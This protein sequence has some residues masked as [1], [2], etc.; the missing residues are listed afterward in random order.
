MHKSR[1]LSKTWNLE[2]NF[3]L[4]IHYEMPEARPRPGEGPELQLQLQT[5]LTSSA[6]GGMVREGER[7]WLVASTMMK[8]KERRKIS[9]VHLSFLF[10]L[11]TVRNHRSEASSSPAPSTNWI[12]RRF[13]PNFFFLSFFG[14]LFFFSLNFCTDDRRSKR[15]REKISFIRRL[16]NVTRQTQP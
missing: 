10:S 16:I 12:C 8:K 11:H 7:G 1:T 4:I 13:L 3:I 2:P 9:F 5:N 6:E 15:E 14:L